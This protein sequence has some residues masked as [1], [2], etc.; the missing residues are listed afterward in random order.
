MLRSKFQSSIAPKND[1]NNNTLRII[2]AGLLFQS[3]IAPKNDR[4]ELNSAVGSRL[5]QFQSSIA[6]K[7]DRNDGGS[8]ICRLVIPVPILDRPEE[9]SQFLI[10]WTYFPNSRF[11]SSIAPKN[12]RNHTVSREG[13]CSSSNPRSPRRT[14]AISRVL[15]DRQTRKVPI[16]DRPEERSQWEIL[17]SLKGPAIEFQSSIA[18]KNDRNRSGGLQSGPG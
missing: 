4:N 18:P 10:S 5:G 7:N 16:L 9:R 3:S 17:R 11:Q 6:P 13:S 8:L 14:I 2:L 12:D 1:R 15:P